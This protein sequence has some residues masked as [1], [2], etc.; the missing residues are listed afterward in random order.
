[1]VQLGFVFVTEVFCWTFA[2][3]G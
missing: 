1:V 3:T 2:G